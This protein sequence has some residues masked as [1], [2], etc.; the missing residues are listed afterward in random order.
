[1]DV[2]QEDEHPWLREEKAAIREWVVERDRPF[3]GVCLGH[4]LLADA[5]GG[6]VGPATVG[7]IGLL[8]IRLT[9]AGRAHPL[10]EGF[11][12]VKRG[13]Q[14]H[15]AE[16]KSLPAGAELLATTADCPIAAFSVGSSAFGLQ[17]HVEATDQSIVDWS[18]GDGGA[19]ALA[20]LHPPGYGP[21]LEQ[22]VVTSL[23]ELIGNSRRL[24]DN[25]MRIALARD[26]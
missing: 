2:W 14:W 17:Y 20:R 19:A 9:E 11:A 15:G 23:G 25:F 13:I 24:Y 16:V 26:L 6:E 4:Q 12:A 18:S 3:L 1:M 5:L 22:R 7:E 21:Q 10:F 8:D